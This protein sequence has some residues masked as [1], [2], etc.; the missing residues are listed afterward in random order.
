MSLGHMQQTKENIQSLTESLWIFSALAVLAET[1][2]LVVLQEKTS[3]PTLK[4]IT[5]LPKTILQQTVNLLVVTGY[6][7]TDDK[8]IWLAP[9]ML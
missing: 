5:Q 9:S 7:I 8:T 2:A 6:L 4:K 3:L 1:G